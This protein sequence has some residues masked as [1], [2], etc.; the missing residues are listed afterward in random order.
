MLAAIPVLVASLLINNIAA[1]R[2]HDALQA[3]ASNRLVAIR[4]LTKGR[5]E[6]YFNT[7]HNQVLTLSE[8]RMVV[9]ALQS[10]TESFHNY[11]HEVVDAVTAEK[12][13]ALEQF[14]KKDF[15]DEY[16]R[17]NNGTQANV[18]AWLSQLDADA[19]ALQ[20]HLIK[21]NPNPLG[22]KH[23][24]TDLADG[25]MYAEHHAIFHPIIR[26]YLELFEF[27]DIFLVD[28][29]SGDIVYSVYKELDY[30]TS[31]KD[32]AFANTGIGEAFRKADQAS[33]ADFVTLVDFA[34]YPPS[35]EGAASFIASPIFSDGKKVGV[36]I[37]Q[38]PI[39]RI[40]KVMTHDSSWMQ[41]GLGESGETYLVGEDT[42]MRS[43][44]RF[45]IEDK[46]NYLEAI[47]ASGV[48]EKTVEM[49]ESKET[50]IGLHPIA[51]DG[52][53][54]A[55]SGKT[56]LEIFPDYRN[57]SVL[58]AYA[59]VSINGVN[60]AIMAEI[61]QEKA[62]RAADELSTELFALTAVV[63]AILILLVV[64]IGLWV[65]GKFSRP[66]INFSR[67]IAEVER[68]ADLTRTIDI[69]SK[70][71]LGEAASAFNSMLGTF[72]SSM[73]QVSDATSQLARDLCY[74]GTN[75]SGC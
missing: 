6:D 63:T 62:F 69:S 5:I 64:V 20:H 46:V 17:L 44:S 48:P 42:L 31:L 3:S 68:D 10:F 32:G 45:L 67:V 43:A 36:L 18:D 34:P 15:S 27:Y 56:G 8:D 37:F 14:Y 39:G 23:K 16:K 55:L 52:S 72:K 29:E 19:V 12:R 24:L 30:A 60:W 13:T 57:V 38:M 28:S 7:I 70:D 65:A 41:V 54:A 47:K 66:I 26:R 73:H 53:R 1:D 51:T 50:S 75:Q 11:R 49:I 40:N 25:S 33:S 2:S 74:H 59:P 58:S 71:E 4:D 9:E 21:A 61:D 35:Y 22:N